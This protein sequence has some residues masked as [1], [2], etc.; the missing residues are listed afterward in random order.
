M[1]ACLYLQGQT[2]LYLGIGVFSVAQS[3]KKML[4]HS[5]REKLTGNLSTVLGQQASTRWTK[6]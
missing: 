1:K 5:E 4:D 2:G 6:P 3:M